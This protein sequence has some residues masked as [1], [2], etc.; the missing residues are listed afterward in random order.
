MS[1]AES[2]WLTRQYLSIG[3]IERSLVGSTLWCTN[4]LFAPSGRLLSKHRKLQP[5]AAERVVWSQGEA[6]FPSVVN[7]PEGPIRTKGDNMP[8]VQTALGRI[9]GLICWESK[10]FAIVSTAEELIGGRLHAAWTIRAV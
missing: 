7:T 8:V 5:T 2:L 1:G 9:G 10:C 3:V 4:L 6:T